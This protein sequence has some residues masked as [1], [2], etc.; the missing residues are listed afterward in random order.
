MVAAQSQSASQFRCMAIHDR[1][2]YE[3]LKKKSSIGKMWDSG[4]L[5]LF[6]LEGCLH[7]IKARHQKQYLRYVALWALQEGEIRNRMLTRQER[8]DQA[9]L[10]L[11]LFIHY[12]LLSFCLL[13]QESLRGIKRAQR[14][15]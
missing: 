9:I 12:F 5:Q 6:S 8:L 3:S 13:L 15:Q 10:S 11:K 4:A 7:R 14:L 2:G 1:P